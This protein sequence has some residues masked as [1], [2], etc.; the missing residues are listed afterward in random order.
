M[1]TVKKFYGTWCTPCK[2]LV[3]IMEQLRVENSGVHFMAIDVDNNADTAAQYGVRSVPT[4][5]IEKNGVEV[6]RFVGAKPKMEY[7]R[8]ISENIN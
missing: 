8:I 2:A 6:T 4:V 7:Q 3:P 1:V 5:I